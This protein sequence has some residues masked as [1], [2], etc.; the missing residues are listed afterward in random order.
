MR[1]A[2]LAVLV[3]LAALVGAAASGAPALLGRASWD[4]ARYQT[5]LVAPRLAAAHSVADGRLPHWWDGSGLGVPLSAEPVHAA[6]Y[7]PSWLGGSGWAVDLIGLLHGALLGA[8]VAGMSAAAWR[9]ARATSLPVAAKLAAAVLPAASGLAAVT[10]VGGQLASLAWLA[11]ALWLAVGWG[12]RVELE[13]TSPKGA[14]FPSAMVAKSCALASSLAAVVLAGAPGLALIA[15]ALITLEV[16]SFS[17]R[18]LPWLALACTLAGLLSA[19]QLLP[20][21]ALASSGALADP[22][23][24]SV[25]PWLG[26]SPGPWLGPSLFTL[27]ALAAPLAAL[28]LVGRLWRWLLSA[29]I[30]A[31]VAAVAGDHAL[32]SLALGPAALA[33][34]AALLLLP[35]SVIGAVRLLES[36][37]QHRAGLARVGGAAFFLA[38]LAVGLASAARTSWRD[39]H[40]LDALPSWLSPQL[41]GPLAEAQRAGA[42]IRV[43]CPPP[44]SLRGAA[45]RD[46]GGPLFTAAGVLRGWSCAQSRDLA[47]AAVE[48]SLWLRGAGLGG[49]LLRRTSI[50]LA[51]VPSSTVNAVGFR[52][53]G[54]DGSWSLVALA[55]RPLAAIYTT[56]LHV[57]DAAEALAGVL[58]APGH[59][60]ATTHQLVVEGAAPAPPSSGTPR[61]PSAV[62]SPAPIA[63]VPP[64]PDEQTAEVPHDHLSHEPVEPATPAVPTVAEPS[65]E[66]C[67]LR[68]WRPGAIDLRC[69]ASAV[70]SIAAIASAWAPGWQVTVDDAARPVLRVEAV[71]RG[72]ALPAAVSLAAPAYHKISWRYQ[73]PAWP[74]ARALTLLGLVILLGLV[75]SLLFS[76]V[77]LRR[78]ARCAILP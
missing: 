47:H 7:P 59:A 34:V 57:S 11:V 23:S 25:G 1:A 76:V 56:S 52:E 15:V 16:A 37:A 73:P 69:S 21:R 66:P 51:I 67:E 65:P 10:L 49:R 74:L 39:R 31:G 40:E 18:R 60:G 36:L 9:R 70:A 2:A 14:G 6:L 46:P 13:Q 68:S 17:P 3:V 44:V 43:F 50:S 61:V 53:L 26:P 42:P 27:L 22:S 20:W 12:R 75:A 4:D 28:A 58:P 72:V 78:R 19:A 71:L 5:Q 45:S 30:L 24:M 32:A 63:P 35:S 64:A 77:V 33:S 62:P 38:I 54:R 8:A 41:P 29:A 48:D 55:S